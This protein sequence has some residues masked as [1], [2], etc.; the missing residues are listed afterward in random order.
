MKINLTPTREK[1]YS[2]LNNVIDPYI[3]CQ[4][5]SMVAGLDVGGFDLGP[6]MTANP[7]KQPEDKLRYFMPHDPDVQ[8]FWKNSHPNNLD[9]PA[10]ELGDCMVFAV[11]KL[12]GKTVTYYDGK[13]TLD[14][15]IGDLANGLPVYTSMKYPDNINFSGK[16]SPIPGH[17]V[18]IVGVD[19]GVLLINDPYKNHLTG[20]R[21]GFNNRY[22]AEQFNRH[23]KGYAVRYRRA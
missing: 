12:Y 19:D 17:I 6:I 15:A 16:P 23:N 10:P 1:F 13:L 3:A 4:V 7:Y 5:T 22:T 14:K 18:L 20:E 8:N 21:D 11:N 9:V 2:Q